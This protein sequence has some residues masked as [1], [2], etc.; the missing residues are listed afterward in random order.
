M[1]HGAAFRHSSSSVDLGPRL[2]YVMAGFLATSASMLRKRPCFLPLPLCPGLSLLFLLL[3]RRP[4]PINACYPSSDGR[5]V[6][7]GKR[8]TM[9]WRHPPLSPISERFPSSTSA[10]SFSPLDKC[11]RVNPSRVTVIV[12]ACIVCCG[13]RILARDIHLICPIAQSLPL[14][15]FLPPTQSV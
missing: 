15:S 5:N 12:P 7:E 6:E 3:C 13:D 2:G 14:P 10:L 1:W 8:A 11:E 4:P 9:R